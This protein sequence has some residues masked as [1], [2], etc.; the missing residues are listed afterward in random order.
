MKNTKATTKCK[1][2]VTYSQNLGK[3][4]E[5]LFTGTGFFLFD[6]NLYTVTE[7]KN[8]FWTS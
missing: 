1:G 3:M 8:F 7:T 4:G 2:L 6:K 5:V